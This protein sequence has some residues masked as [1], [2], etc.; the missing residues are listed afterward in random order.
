MVDKINKRGDGTDITTNLNSINKRSTCTKIKFSNSTTFLAACACSD[1]EECERLLS[2]NLVNINCTNID[3]LTALHQACI[4]DNA[5]MVKFLLDHGADVNFCDN[6]GWT[7][8]HATASCGN[9]NVAR[10]LLDHD[11][12]PRIVNNDGELSQDLTDNFAIKDIIDAKLKE[13]GVTDVEAL[14][15]QEENC[16]L[17]DVNNWIQTGIVGKLHNDSFIFLPPLNHLPFLVSMYFSNI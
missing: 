9:K 10:L 15:K 2:Q 1:Y 4:D 11:A 3:G 17:R 16:M 7:P 8:L 12:D 14:R 6:E 5:P 13:L